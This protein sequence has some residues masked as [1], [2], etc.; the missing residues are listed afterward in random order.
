M[1]PMKK[2]TLLLVPALLAFSACAPTPAKMQALLETHPEI[3]VKAIE[4]N[5]D[6]IMGALNKAAQ[7]AQQKSQEDQAKEEQ[8]KNEAEFNNPL[9]A[10][11]NDNTPAMGSKS[12]PITIVEYT[13]F[14]CPFCSRGYQT[15]ETV[16]KTYGDKIRVI[17]KNLPL[18]M[19]PAAMPAAKR[20]EALKLQSPEKAYSFYHYVFSNQEKIGH[21]TDKFLDAAVKKAGGDLA[22]VK[23]DMDSEKVA[24]TIK[25][26]MD[27]AAK[28]GISGTPGFIIQG[29]SVRGAYP[30]ET[31]KTIIDRK[32]Q[33]K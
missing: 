5:P 12:A 6:L 13:D 4:K 32:L 31:F 24:A 22:R 27:E 28:F 17:V 3:L 7:S 1:K 30:F 21:D 11:F 14:Q 15:L 16:R 20:F 8:A 10:E 19:H 33:G 26:D 23:K 29:V 9:K 2:L 25:A 18:P